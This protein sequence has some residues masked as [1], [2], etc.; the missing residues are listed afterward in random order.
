[1]AKDGDVMAL[2]VFS[3]RIGRWMKTEPDAIDIT[4]KSARPEWMC[5]APS[6][7]ILKPALEA[8]RRAE[9]L[10]EETCGLDPT[11]RSAADSWLAQAWDEYVPL[12]MAEMRVSYGMTQ[13]N[14]AWGN[15]EDL[16]VAHGTRANRPMWDNLLSRQRV[17]LCCYC[18]DAEHCHRTIL[19]RDILTRLGAEDCGEMNLREA[20]REI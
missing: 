14:P 13:A 7:A 11:A 12:F 6:W 15:D 18:S 4:R 1:M 17:V 19:R 10:L 3:A 9:A 2:R 20:G 5:F 16:A 8:R